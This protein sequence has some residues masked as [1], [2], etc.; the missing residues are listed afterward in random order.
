MIRLKAGVS[1]AGFFLGSS[2]EVAAEDRS[3]V[4]IVKKPPRNIWAAG[5]MGEAMSYLEL[6]LLRR[7]VENISEVHH[8]VTGIAIKR[9]VGRRLSSQFL[10]AVVGGLDRQT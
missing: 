7:L 9:L 1:N 10:G 3:I 6:F 4:L 2:N 8:V 5:G